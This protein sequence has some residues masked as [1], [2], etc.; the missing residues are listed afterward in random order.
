MDGYKLLYEC[1]KGRRRGEVSWDHKKSIECLWIR[2]SGVITQGE[3]RFGVCYWPPNQNGEADE[4]FLWLLKELLDP[5]NLVLRGDFSDPGSCE[6]S[7]SC[8]SDTAPPCFSSRDGAHGD[9]PSQ[10]VCS[11]ALMLHSHQNFWFE[12]EFPHSS[13]RGCTS[14]PICQQPLAPCLFLWPRGICT[15]VC[16]LTAQCPKPDQVICSLWRA[17][18]SSPH[19]VHLHCS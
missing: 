19:F 17:A 15:S 10:S 1:G 14:F 9:H 3:V 18:S 11:F 2:T 7:S 8:G 6:S 12:P 4:T 16:A 5:Q 13:S